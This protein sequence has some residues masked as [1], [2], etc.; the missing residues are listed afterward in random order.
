MRHTVLQRVQWIFIALALLAFAGIGII[1]ARTA[2][3]GLPDANGLQP[4][5]I[6][7]A[8]WNKQLVLISGH[9]G[10]DSGATCEDK[11]GNTTLQEVDINAAVAEAAAERLRKAGATVTIMQE[12]D[13]RLEGLK[14]DALLSIHADSCIDASGYKA[15]FYT[16]TQIRPVDQRLLACIDR[17]YSAQTGLAHS[18]N[19]VTHNMTEYHAFR[20]IDAQTPA[21]ILETGFL[22][23]DR[24]LLEHHPEIVGKGVADSL[25]CFLE[26][27]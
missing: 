27:K 10:N 15:A 25:I 17:I 16:D 2:G 23:G 26:G 4:Q 24:D 5:G 1:G 18:P 9:A 21:A 6:V 7:S 20:V 13:S 14:A 11:N 8:A 3:Y 22:G 12:F 19:T